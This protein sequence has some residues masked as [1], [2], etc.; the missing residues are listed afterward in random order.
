MKKMLM[1]LGI[2]AVLAALP[3]ASCRKKDKPARVVKAHDA[4]ETVAYKAAR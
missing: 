2:F 1:V 4:K 3:A